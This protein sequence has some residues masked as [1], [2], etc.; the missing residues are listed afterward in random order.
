MKTGALITMLSRGPIAADPG[1][2]E[3]RLAA[4]TALG[5]LVIAAVGLVVLVAAALRGA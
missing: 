1:T 4:A 5:A 3:R 2:T